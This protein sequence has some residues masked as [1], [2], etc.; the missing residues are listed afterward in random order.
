MC[1]KLTTSIDGVIHQ[2]LFLVFKNSSFSLLPFRA[3]V[4]RSQLQFI[5]LVNHYHFVF[6]LNLDNGS[7]VYLSQGEESK[8]PIDRDPHNSRHCVVPGK[9][10]FTALYFQWEHVNSVCWQIKTTISPYTGVHHGGGDDVGLP[11]CLGSGQARFG[12]ANLILHNSDMH[13]G[14][15]NI[16]LISNQLAIGNWQLTFCHR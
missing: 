11:Y 5:I 13:L 16:A 2:I 1:C 3:Y 9:L 10:H 6:I 15:L 14:T 8:E 7:M 4:W 12:Y